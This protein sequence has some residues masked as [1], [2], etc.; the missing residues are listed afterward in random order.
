MLLESLKPEK[1]DIEIQ[2]LYLFAFS[3]SKYPI[4]KPS[5]FNTTEKYAIFFIAYLD[6]KT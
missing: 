2:F 6:Q 4:K 1:K 3:F 5:S